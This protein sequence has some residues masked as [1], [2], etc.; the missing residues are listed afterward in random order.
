[1]DEMR[2]DILFVKFLDL[3]EKDKELIIYLYEF[4][5]NDMYY[6]NEFAEEDITSFMFNHWVSLIIRIFKNPEKLNNYNSFTNIFYL[7]YAV[8]IFL[9][10]HRELIDKEIKKHTPCGKPS[11]AIIFYGTVLKYN[12]LEYLDDYANELHQRRI[13]KIIVKS[14]ISEFG[15]IT[16]CMKNFFIDMKAEE[17]STFCEYI[18]LIYE[19]LGNNDELMLRENRVSLINNFVLLGEFLEDSCKKD[20]YAKLWNHIKKFFKGISEKWKFN[21]LYCTCFLSFDIVDEDFDIIRRLINPYIYLFQNTK[22]HDKLKNLTD[23]EVETIKTFFEKEMLKFRFIRVDTD[24]SGDEYDDEDGIYSYRYGGESFFLEDKFFM[25]YIIPEFLI[26]EEIK[27]CYEKHGVFREEYE[28][29]YLHREDTDLFNAYV[30]GTLNE[31]MYS[32]SSLDKINIDGKKFNL[33]LK[34]KDFIFNLPSDNQCII[35]HNYLQNIHAI[36]IHKCGHIECLKCFKENGSKEV[37]AIDCKSNILK[38]KKIM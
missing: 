33:Q 35:C 2:N 30:S 14:I 11:M 27:Y 7:E 20:I 18:S 16:T 8:E 37:C 1:M 26:K 12:L 5:K 4:G 15:K 36:K 3:L 34:I 29:L 22:N 32:E 25:D 17:I 23:K 19:F 9:N 24:D 38:G 31:D 28:K 13:K 10:F 21:K 6:E